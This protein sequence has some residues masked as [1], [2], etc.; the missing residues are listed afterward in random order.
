[1]TNNRMI[2]HSKVVNCHQLF[3]AFSYVLLLL[4]QSTQVVISVITIIIPTVINLFVYSHKKVQFL[5]NAKTMH[6]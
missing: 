2:K 1:M 5:K 6:L 3:C 4:P